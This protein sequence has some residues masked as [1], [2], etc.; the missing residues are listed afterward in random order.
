MLRLALIN[1]LVFSLGAGLVIFSITSLSLQYVQGH[2]DESVTAELAILESDYRIDGLGGVIGLIQE[3]DRL[4]SAWHGRIYRLESAEGQLL[5]GDFPHWPT[6]LVMDA[7]PIALHAQVPPDNTEIQWMVAARVLPAGERLLVGFDR[8][9]T[10]ALASQVRRAAGW[11]VPLALLIALVG[12]F[13]A[14]R[15]AARQIGT[16]NASARR[17]VAGDLQHRIPLQG[18]GDELDRLTQTLNTMLDRINELIAATRGATDAIAHD[19]RSPLARLRAALEDGQRRPPDPA[20]L[21][22]WLQ[23]RVEDID[24]VLGSFSALLQLATVESGVLRSQFRPVGLA[25]VV[26]DAMSLYEAMAADIGCDL[27]LRGVEGN[28]PLMGDRHLLFQ[29]VANLLDNALKFTPPAGQVLLT[30]TRE[31]DWMQLDIEDNGPGIPTGDEDRVFD[32]L[33]RHDRTRQSQGY[34]LGLSLV[35]AI[36]RL[37]GGDCKVVPHAGGALLRMRLP[38]AQRNSQR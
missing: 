12:S 38:V 22:P 28:T 10:L 23:E 36:A 13:A 19:L 2:L 14:S 7:A 30:L 16:I 29:A 35:R 31:G 37:H 8:A 18:S 17:I 9:E 6:E 20:L 4:D 34:G 32:R 33:F 27:Q 3:R 15:T 1:T 5:A 25:T 11:S 26:S 24:Q 21:A